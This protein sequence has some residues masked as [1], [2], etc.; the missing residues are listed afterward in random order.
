MDRKRDNH[1]RK[2]TSADVLTAQADVA[3]QR[4]SASTSTSAKGVGRSD[5]GR[6]PALPKSSSETANGLRPKY[7][8]YNIWDPDSEFTPNT[9]DWTLTAEP[10]K[11]SPQSALDDE[12]VSKTIRENPHL[13]KIV[14]PTCV[15]VFKAYLSSHPNQTFVKSV[16]NGL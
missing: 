8:R 3:S 6:L 11:G 12:P 2:K 1:L 14:T 9:S 7:L 13:F 16:C 15:D 4:T 5:M 10:L